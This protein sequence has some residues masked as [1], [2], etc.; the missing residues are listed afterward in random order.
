MRIPR[1]YGVVSAIALGVAIAAGGIA[2]AGKVSKKSPCDIATQYVERIQAG[3]YDEVG[4]LWADD[5]VF[6]SPQ[7]KIIHGK[8]AIKAF[9]AQFLATITP[10]VRAARPVVDA[11]ANVCV[12]ELEV[13][14]HRE[15]DGQS[16]TDTVNGQW[17]TDKDAP[18]S[19]S[20]MDRFTIN[21][22]GKIQHLIV[23]LAPP[24]R[25]SAD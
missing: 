15:P 21:P 13:R 10:I 4:E 23:Y 18:Y 11:S 25:W 9:Y 14:M 8:P 12:M 2:N 20:A 5:A 6:Y 24:S 16:K 1:A 17:K 3:R 19:R 22:Q 7:G